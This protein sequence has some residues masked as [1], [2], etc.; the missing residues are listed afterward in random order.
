VVKG[1]ALKAAWDLQAGLDAGTIVQCLS[2]FWYDEIDLFSI[3]ANRHYP[4]PR[5]RAFLSFIAKNVTMFVPK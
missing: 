2:E 3:C 4:S 5:I 1:I